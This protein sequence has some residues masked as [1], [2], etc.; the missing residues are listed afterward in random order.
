MTRFT[1]KDD[2][3]YGWQMIPGY[4]GEHCVPYCCP[5]YMQEVAPL[6]SSKGLLRLSFWNTGYAEGAQG[7][8]QTLKVL[9][10]GAD[11][12][13][14]AIIHDPAE[15]PERC[16]VI[17]HIEFG[18]IERFCPELWHKH[19]PLHQG[20]GVEGSVSMYLDSVFNVNR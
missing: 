12:L 1:L 19:P 20:P 9:H 18:W 13:I 4:V 2:R 3:W 16:A 6:K 8:E 5:I 17:S 7:F 10:R 15:T 14:A 11:Y